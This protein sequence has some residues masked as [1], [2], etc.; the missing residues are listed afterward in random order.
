M[1]AKV[2]AKGPVQETSS[3]GHS[4]PKRNVPRLLCA[5]SAIFASGAAIVVG[6]NLYGHKVVAFVLLYPIPV[7]ITVSSVAI[8]ILLCRSWKA[9]I[10]RREEGEKKAFGDIQ[11][12]T[13]ATQEV[14]LTTTAL[15]EFHSKIPELSRRQSTYT[16]RQ[17]IRSQFE[18]AILSAQSHYQIALK[19]TNIIEQFNTRVVSCAR[20]SQLEYSQTRTNLDAIH[21][22]LQMGRR[23]HT[24]VGDWMIELAQL[25][26]YKK[27][28]DE[29]ESYL[30]KIRNAKNFKELRSFIS[31]SE[32]LLKQLN[33]IQTK[34]K[35]KSRLCLDKLTSELTGL[36]SIQKMDVEQAQERIRKQEIEY[37]EITREFLALTSAKKAIDPGYCQHLV[38]IRIKLT[39]LCLFV[40]Q[41]AED[42]RDLSTMNA[43]IETCQKF[44][45]IESHRVNLNSDEN[46]KWSHLFKGTA[47]WWGWTLEKT[48]LDT[49]ITL[50]SKKISRF[51]LVSEEDSQPIFAVLR[52]LQNKFPL[53][54]ERVQSDETAKNLIA[55]FYNAALHVNES[56][57]G[58]PLVACF[59]RMV[60]QADLR[61]KSAT[62]MVQASMEEIRA[63]LGFH[64]L[65]YIC[66]KYYVAWF[67]IVKEF[68]PREATY[69]A[70]LPCTKQLFAL[71]IAI[72]EL[73]IKNAV[74]ESLPKEMSV[75]KT[76]GILTG[77]IPRIMAFAHL[78]KPAVPLA[79]N[80]P[81]EAHAIVKVKK[82]CSEFLKT[83]KTSIEEIEK[84][85]LL[86]DQIKEMMEKDEKALGEMTDKINLQMVD[87]AIHQLKFIVEAGKR[88]FVLLSKQID[89]ETLTKKMTGNRY[90]VFEELVKFFMSEEL[91]TYAQR[92]ARF[93]SIYMPPSSSS[94]QAETA[95]GEEARTF[96]PGGTIDILLNSPPKSIEEIIKKSGLQGKTFRE[97]ISQTFQR[98]PRWQLLTQE[99]ARAVDASKESQER[100][101]ETARYG[102]DIA[103]V[104]L[105]LSSVLEERAKKI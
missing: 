62:Q 63:H 90:T 85:P 45:E 27:L 10:K 81:L 32:I 43:A 4:P 2:T 59:L 57:V 37:S 102:A 52:N 36:Q 74:E 11:E 66:N 103:Q 23:A 38:T 101:M 17:T 105:D 40:T 30:I 83:E 56:G 26:V 94:T 100:M 22:G 49:T 95:L 98:P 31:Q 77:H 88:A 33:D 80:R 29:V 25:E 76:V 78:A 53:I 1:A 7:A 24:I 65:I 91:R 68:V 21:R 35:I 5:I 18:L 99:L 47:F 13:K 51:L 34:G 3:Q 89:D 42:G 71:L 20:L 14:D 48:K 58:H 75:E 39:S 54:W 44:L 79:D 12:I 72:S 84:L 19:A 86:F 6:A 50:L 93:V 92:M 41:T 60:K 61:G 55:A 9:Y 104:L 8:L 46:S 87:R 15:A 73:E 70:M 96:A 82:I 16:L 28:Y 69:Q 67:T 97:L 64:A